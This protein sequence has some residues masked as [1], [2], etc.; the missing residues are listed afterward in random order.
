MWNYFFSFLKKFFELD[1][2]ELFARFYNLLIDD[3][4]VYL[5]IVKVHLL[6]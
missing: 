1:T 3:K 5:L 6:L 4:P 2:D